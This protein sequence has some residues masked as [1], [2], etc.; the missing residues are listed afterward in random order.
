[1]L[2]RCDL[3]YNSVQFLQVDDVPLD[4]VPNV[5]SKYHICVVKNRRLDSEVI[6]RASEM[7][8]IMQFGVGL[9]GHPTI[10]SVLFFTKL[11]NVFL[12]CFAATFY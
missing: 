4:D 9:E 6:A 5:I 2:Q 10:S 8:L 7:K 1:M 3:F 12:C 11:Q